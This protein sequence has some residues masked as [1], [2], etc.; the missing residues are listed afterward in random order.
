MHLYHRLNGTNRRMHTCKVHYHTFVLKRLLSNLTK[1]CLLLVHTILYHSVHL[2]SA[3]LIP[4]NTGD[5]GTHVSPPIRC[6]KS[7]EVKTKP[8]KNG[9]IR[10]LGCYATAS[11]VVNFDEL[12]EAQPSAKCFFIQ[13]HP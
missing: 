7:T 12:V 2:Q 8:V 11:C 10:P 13:T 1:G 3:I 6:S 9:R 5:K 4:F